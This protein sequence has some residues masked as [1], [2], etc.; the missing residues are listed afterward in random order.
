[1]SYTLR[2]YSSGM[3]RSTSTAPKSSQTASFVDF[4]SLLESLALQPEAAPQQ[5]NPPL[6]TNS[7][8]R[9]TS[10]LPELDSRILS[11]TRDGIAT[12]TVALATG[13]RKQPKSVA[14][15]L[16]PTKPRRNDDTVLLSY[17]QALRTHSR[18]HAEQAPETLS[19][20]SAQLSEST[21]SHHTATPAAECNPVQPPPTLLTSGK[22]KTS[23]ST[24][25]GQQKALPVIQQRNSVLTVAQNSALDPEV[26]ITSQETEISPVS[27][28]S[29][30][31][32]SLI[33]D[34]LSLSPS[35]GRNGGK[36]QSTT[37][38]YRILD[39]RCATISVRLSSSEVE[40]LR[41]RAEESQMS[42]SSYLRSCVLE[43]DQL[44][45]QVKQ[46]LAELRVLAQTSTGSDTYARDREI[47]LHPTGAAKKQD[48]HLRQWWQGNRGL[49]KRQ[50]KAN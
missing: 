18:Y 47:H 8:K 14:P 11:A 44:R 12:D 33:E 15:P 3:S 13:G 22:T 2:A 5:N 40:R 6:R 46:A 9:P 32:D 30:L 42:I 35:P 45:A 50:G 39:Q 38:S 4:A 19:A 25:I 29:P 37:R 41:S 21:P 49:W 48:S 17:E 43:A 23:K 31:D 26:N 27:H 28:L 36:T 7:G 20:K 24:K 34:E 10:D 16:R 1:M